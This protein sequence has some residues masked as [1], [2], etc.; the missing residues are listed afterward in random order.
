M[1]GDCRGT[2]WTLLVTFWSVQ[3]A[4]PLK[5]RKIFLSHNVGNYQPM[6]LKTS[7][8]SEYL[9]W[10][11]ARLL[12]KYTECACHLLSRLH[13]IWESHGDK[14]DTAASSETQLHIYL[15]YNWPTQGTELYYSFIWYAGSYMFRHPCAIFRE[16]LMSSWFSWKQKCWWCLSNNKQHK[17]FCFQVTHEDMRSSLKMAHGCRNM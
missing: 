9:S 7:Q 17:R 4:W 8:K 11:S 10:F 13:Q 15:E 1:S 16:L 14:M 12:W 5:K 6:P 2:L 3:S